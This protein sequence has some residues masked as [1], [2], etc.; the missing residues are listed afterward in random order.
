MKS[1]LLF[2]FQNKLTTRRFYCNIMVHQP[3][4]CSNNNEKQVFFVLGGPG[5][6][7]GTQCEL[8]SKEFG[9]THLSAGELLRLERLSAT[10]NGNLIESYLKE[11]KIVPVAITLELLKQAIVQSKNSLILVDGFPRNWDNIN[12]WESSNINNFC[13][14][15]KVLF[16]DCPESVLEH[17][18]LTRGLTSGR[19]DD[20]TETV[21]KRLQTYK[22]STLP[23]L[24]YYEQNKKLI[25]INGDQ[26]KDLVFEEFKVVLSKFITSGC[27]R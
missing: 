27:L 7:K 25:R 19:S 17:R 22:E 3:D 2:G 24:K 1:Y 23:I 12:G 11:G 5:A 8:L 13:K 10:A 6:G 26:S 14:F 4:I 16:I 18:I 9:L 21:K 20:N 15:Q